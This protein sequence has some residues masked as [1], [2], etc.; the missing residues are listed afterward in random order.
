MKT[1]CLGPDL[2]MVSDTRGCL[3]PV[4]EVITVIS[5]ESSPFLGSIDLLLVGGVKVNKL[6]KVLTCA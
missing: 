2:I 5:S 3:G 1:G 4:V 6:S